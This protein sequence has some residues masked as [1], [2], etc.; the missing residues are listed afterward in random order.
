LFL[1]LRNS[2]LIGKVLLGPWGA[3]FQFCR[4]NHGMAAGPILV[5]GDFDVSHESKKVHLLG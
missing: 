4:S 3:K 2:A 5:S 1:L